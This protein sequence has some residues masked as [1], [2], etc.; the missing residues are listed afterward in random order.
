[1]RVLICWL[2]GEDLDGAKKADKA[3]P[4]PLGTAIKQ[5]L[6]EIDDQNIKNKIEISKLQVR[7]LLM[8]Q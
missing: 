7:T 1:M 4:G 8:S 2:A 5:S 6:M 3:T